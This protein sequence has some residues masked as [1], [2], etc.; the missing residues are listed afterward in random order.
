MQG[1]I[2]KESEREK[3]LLKAIRFAVLEVILVLISD[4]F[5]ALKLIYKKSWCCL[6]PDGKFG[7]SSK[8]TWTSEPT[9]RWERCW[10]IS[11]LLQVNKKCVD[12]CLFTC[13]GSSNQSKCLR[14]SKKPPTTSLGADQMLMINCYWSRSPRSFIQS[15]EL[16]S[17]APALAEIR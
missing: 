15:H 2:Q 7:D 9:Y 4:L 10:L 11:C 3:Y 16:Q 12:V 17:M 13:R 14:L 6:Y 8:R 1:Y 5:N